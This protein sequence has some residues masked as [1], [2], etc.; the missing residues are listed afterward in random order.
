[1]GVEKSGSV[2]LRTVSPARD[3]ADHGHD[4]DVRVELAG[5]GVRELTRSV[6]EVVAVTLGHETC[7]R[8]ALHPFQRRSH[9][10]VLGQRLHDRQAGMVSREPVQAHGLWFGRG[11]QGTRRDS[12]IGGAHGQRRQRDEACRALPRLADVLWLGLPLVVVEDHAEIRAA[13]REPGRIPV[14]G[15]GVVRDGDK[16]PTHA[17][18]PGAQYLEALSRRWNRRELSH[19]NCQYGALQRTAH[20]RQLS[21]RR[22]GAFRARIRLRASAGRWRGPVP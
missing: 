20:P 19:N 3:G 8:V 12:V 14:D 2:M 9:G 1:M 21:V 18:G 11:G 22:G 5:G 15:A 10:D 17:R 4:A 13:K 7:G 6:E 16:R